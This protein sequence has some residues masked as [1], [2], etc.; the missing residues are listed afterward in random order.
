MSA[1]NSEILWKVPHRTQHRI[2]NQ[3]AEAA[4]RTIQ[5]DVTEVM[6]QLNI[7]LAIAILN[8]LIDHFNSSRRS[9]PARSTLAT[10]FIR[11]EFHRETGHL[12]HIDLIVESD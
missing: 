12:C 3:T 8:D 6:Q 10:R 9:D 2:G 5:H 1:R 7:R 11:A 4:Q